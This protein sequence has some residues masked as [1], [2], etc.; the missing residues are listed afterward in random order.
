[1][2]SVAK[3]F[4]RPEG[5]PLNLLFSL[6]V[7]Q[8]LGFD[9]RLNMVRKVKSLSSNLKQIDVRCFRLLNIIIRTVRPILLLKSK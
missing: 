1:M 8:I 9:F 4:L 3:H 6:I 7:E 2:L 5:A